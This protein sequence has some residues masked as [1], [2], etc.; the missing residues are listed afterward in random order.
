MDSKHLERNAPPLDLPEHAA[1]FPRSELLRGQSRD[2]NNAMIIHDLE[3]THRICREQIPH[4]FDT[5]LAPQPFF[6]VVK[7]DFTGFA[8]EDFIEQGHTAYL[9]LRPRCGHRGAA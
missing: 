9:A 3:F 6:R 5:F 2:H 7:L 4:L 1:G 8:V